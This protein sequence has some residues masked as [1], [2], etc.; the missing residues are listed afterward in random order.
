MEKE[1]ED[2]LLGF[3]TNQ[4]ALLPSLS[5]QYIRGY[6]NR[7]SFL[8]LRSILERFVTFGKDNERIILMPGLRGIGKT[9]LLFQ[10][11]NIF[12]DNLKPNHIVYFSCDII[13]KQFNSNLQEVIEVYEK[14]ILGTQFETLNEKT[15]ILVDEAHYDENWQSTV[16]SIFDRS[17]NVFVIVSGSSSIGIEINTDLTRRM[18]MER[19]YPLNFAEYLLLKKNVY[20]IPQL[21]SN[22]RDAIFLTEDINEAFNKLVSLN[23]EVTTKLKTKIPNLETELENFL[24]I[25]G[26]PF[27]LPIIKDELIF[28]KITSILDK[29]IYQ[30]IITFYPSCKGIVDRI[31]PILHVMAEA[32]DKISYESLLKF[33]P[34]SSK[35]SASEIIDAL[36]TAGVINPISIEG[37]AARMARNSYKYYFATPTIR[38]SLLWM[39]GKFSKDSKNLGLLL[40]NAV[41]N[42]LNKIK[43]YN[44][45]LIQDIRYMDGD[46]KPDFQLITGGKKM[47]VESGWG[48]KGTKQINSEDNQNSKFSII[49]SNIHYPK[50]D[51]D[52]K[53]IFIPKELFLLMS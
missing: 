38:S 27:T 16:K 10:L 21:T 34:E 5:T 15:V 18:H 4:I 35:S 23:E 32:S 46:T 12:R 50:L 8:K 2:L 3:V 13:S 24:S 48:D 30:D 19:I 43:I 26:F 9:T 49:V 52:K 14:K 39:I 17:K 31:F 37:S 44:P 1:K 51:N 33:I 53:I 7:I 40:E 36:S 29:I 47:L 6:P 45:N 41:F 25:G 11:Y 20:P 22:L 42:T 28:G